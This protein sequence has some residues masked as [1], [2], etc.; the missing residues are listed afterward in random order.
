MLWLGLKILDLLA[1]LLA[2]H[3]ERLRQCDF[4]LRDPRFLHVG[5]LAA[6]RALLWFTLFGGDGF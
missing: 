4:E 5:N 6:Q 1:V 3:L 2:Q